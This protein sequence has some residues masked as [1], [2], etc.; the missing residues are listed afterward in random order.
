[1]PIWACMECRSGHLCNAFHLTATVSSFACW[2]LFTTRSAEGYATADVYQSWSPLWQKHGEKWQTTYI[3]L[4][5]SCNLSLVLCHWDV[6]VRCNRLGH[7]LH[8]SPIKGLPWGFTL[9]T[10]AQTSKGPSTLYVCF[11]KGFG[12]ELTLRRDGFNLGRCLVWGQF[13]PDLSGDT[14]L[15]K[16]EWALWW[17]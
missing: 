1:M 15:I 4:W 6:H 2:Q 13:Q 16:K 10:R 17:K 5:L 9:S 14:A 7:R 8:V 11:S 12:W 3:L